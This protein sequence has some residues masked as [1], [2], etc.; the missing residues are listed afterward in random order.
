MNN[1]LEALLD[2]LE[3]YNSLG[4]AAQILLHAV[5]GEDV[6]GIEDYHPQTIEIINDFLEQAKAFVQD[7][8]TVEQMQSKLSYHIYYGQ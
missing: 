8:D 1:S 5:S 2:L 7:V 4:L 3:Y 6:G